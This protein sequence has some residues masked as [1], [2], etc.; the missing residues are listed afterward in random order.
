MPRPGPA[1]RPPRTR[2]PELQVGPRDR[3]RDREATAQRSRVPNRVFGPRQRGSPS[4][5]TA[6]GHMEVLQPAPP[7]EGTTLYTYNK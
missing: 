1:L 2:R 3:D 4:W 5:T 6:T 7:P